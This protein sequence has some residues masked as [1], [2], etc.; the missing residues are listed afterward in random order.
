LDTGP[1]EEIWQVARK[2]RNLSTVFV[3]VAFPDEASALAEGSG[4]MTPSLIRKELDYLP[5]HVHKIACHLKPAYY[6]RI[7]DQV[8]RLAIPNL[9]I[10]CP[11][12]EYDA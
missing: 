11:G 9:S 4:H 6:D 8:H 2:T 5:A 1:T 3:D 7:V 12:R 10:G